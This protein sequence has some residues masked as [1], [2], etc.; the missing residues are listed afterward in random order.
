MA[1]YPPPVYHL[2]TVNTIFNTNDFSQSETSLSFANADQRYLFKTGADTSVANTTFNNAV[3][4]NSSLTAY[5]GISVVIGGLSVQNS[6]ISVTGGTII[7]N[8][9]PILAKAGLTVNGASTFD[10]ITTAGITANSLILANAGLNMGNTGITLGTYMP[11][12]NQ[13]GYFS[14]AAL[15]TPTNLTSGTIKNLVSITLPAGSYVLHYWSQFYTAGTA[16]TATQLTVGL[17]TTNAD[18]NT[19]RNDIFANQTVSNFSTPG[20]QG[21][22][23]LSASSSTTIYLNTLASWTPTGT[24]ITTNYSYI[25]SIRVG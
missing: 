2:G 21:V 23:M 7:S 24:P 19:T 16:V 6:N 10:G 13:L 8:S 17:G 9:N 5:N 4:L 15:T 11:T 18:V 1:L 14:Q 25:R 22:F 20:L 12:V 3:S